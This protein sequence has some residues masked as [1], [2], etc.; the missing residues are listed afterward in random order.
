MRDPLVPLVLLLLL[1]FVLLM[2]CANNPKIPFHVP[3][4][5]S[6]CVRVGS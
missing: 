5:P 4:M 1:E 6:T 2:L 3:W